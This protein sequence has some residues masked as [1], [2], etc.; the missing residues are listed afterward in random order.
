MADTLANVRGRVRYEID[1]LKPSAYTVSTFRLNTIISRN[2]SLLGGK[3]IRSPEATPYVAV[4]LT[5]GT[6]DYRVGTA[7]EEHAAIRQVIRLSDGY[8]LEP[9]S[10]EYLVEQY[11][12][13]SSSAAGQGKPA[14][15]AVWEDMTAGSGG[16]T[17]R[18]RVA[19]TPDATETTLRAYRAEVVY[20]VTADTDYLPFGTEALRIVELMSAVD[21]VASMPPDE[22]AQRKIDAS[23]IAVWRDAIKDGIRNEN[24][25]RRVVN[26]QTQR[27]IAVSEY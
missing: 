21:A 26:G 14:F 13:D 10:L 7:T 16:S 6:Y 1:D 19:P 4:S 12:Q 20:A 11:R 9:T 24:F 18:M 17:T 22:R 15:Y 25:R 5:Q 2:S 23:I 3:L 27:C 8:V